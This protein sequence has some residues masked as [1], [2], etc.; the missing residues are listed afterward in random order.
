MTS[1]LDTKKTY[2]NAFLK[3]DNDN[4]RAIGDYTGELEEFSFTNIDRRVLFIN[5]LIITIEDNSRFKYNKY[6]A[7]IILKKGLKLYFTEKS[8][9]KYIIGDNLPIK[10]NKDWINYSCKQE[11]MSFNGSHSFL[12]ITFNFHKGNNAII[13]KKNDKISFELFDNFCKLENQIFYIE[14]FYIKI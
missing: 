14:G 5:K 7:D 3:N 2:F 6:A 9:K 12:K 11:Q 8:V 13:L 1:H 10:T 4:F